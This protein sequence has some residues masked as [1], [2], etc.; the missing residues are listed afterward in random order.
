MHS[1]KT[2]L[3]EREESLSRIRRTLLHHHCIDTLIP[4]AGSQGHWQLTKDREVRLYRHKK[5]E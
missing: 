3:E 4:L 2:S 5:Y 1:C